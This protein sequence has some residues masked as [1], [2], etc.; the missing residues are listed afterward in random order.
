MP[1]SL[2]RTSILEC[3]PCGCPV[4]SGSV[5]DSFSPHSNLGSRVSAVSA[6]ALEAQRGPFICYLTAE[7][8]REQTL[9][10]KPPV[11]VRAPSPAMEAGDHFISSACGLFYI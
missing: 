7:P 8:C 4:L 6:A 11:I 10:I 9:E 1:Y 5:D 2:F 3:F